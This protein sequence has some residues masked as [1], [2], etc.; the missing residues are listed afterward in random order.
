MRQKERWVV[1]GLPESASRRNGSSGMRPMTISWGAEVQA[2]KGRCKRLGLMAGTGAAVKE[3]GAEL[4]P[5]YFIDKRSTGR[6]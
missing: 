1:V 6:I 2:S 5:R 3:S 4:S